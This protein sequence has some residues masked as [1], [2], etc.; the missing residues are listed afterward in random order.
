MNSDQHIPTPKARDME[1]AQPLLETQSCRP[2]WRLNLSH[3]E[4]ILTQGLKKLV[5]MLQEPGALPALFSHAPSATAQSPLC[6][7][8]HRNTLK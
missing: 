5:W 4:H 8:S 7:H 6:H 3:E 1:G 2:S